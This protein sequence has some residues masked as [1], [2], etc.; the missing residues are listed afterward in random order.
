VIPRTSLLLTWILV[1]IGALVPSWVEAGDGIAPAGDYLP[2]ADG[3]VGIEEK[4]GAQLPLDL[5]LR[6]EAE[7]PITLG[8][9]ID[10]KP[11]IL[12]P[13]YYRCPMICN[14]VLRN[15]VDTL[16]E[17]PQDFSAG[18]KFNVVAISFDPKE[19]CEHA[20]AKKSVVIQE[21]GREGAEKGWRFLTGSK[22]A[23]AALMGTIGYRYEFDKSY[24]EYNHPTG[25]IIVSPEGKLTRYFMGLRYT[26]EFRING[27]KTT[28]RLSLIEAADGK[29]GSLLDNLYLK[30]YRFDHL[31]KGY[32]PNVLLAVQIGGV[33]TL[34][35]V[36][37]FVSRAILRE[38]YHRGQSS[39]TGF[40]DPRDARTGGVPALAQTNDGL[41]SGGT[42]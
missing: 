33:I 31:K 42:A 32:A 40:N 26:G 13:M 17:M 1:A 12:I 19:H 4:L 24:K 38:R 22:D 6:D 36:A 14:E 11:T 35:L 23:V 30:C 34:L 16:R 29:G 27:G 2:S 10:G 28:L 41:P 37:F 21:Y 7:Q 20:S 39:A 18:G 5:K 3:L 9:C 8:E 15:L 25:I